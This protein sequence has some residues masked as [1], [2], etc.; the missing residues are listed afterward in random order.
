MRIS[1][2]MIF[3]S[4]VAR[5]SDLQASTLKTQQQISTG[6]RVLTPADDPIAAARALEVTQS[7]SINT[8]LTTNRKNANDSLSLEESVL[9]NVTGLYQDVKTLVVNAGNGT[10]SDSER[11]AMASALSGRL[12]ELTGLAN[13]RDGGG[14]YIFSGYQV[15]NPAF[16]TGVAGVTYNG[17]QGQRMLQVSPSQQMAISDT[18]DQ[19]FQSIKNG[20]GTFIAAGQ[21][22]VNAAGITLPLN[23]GSGVISAGNVT[24]PGALTGHNYEVDFAVTAGVTTYSVVDTTSS[25]TLS[26][27]NPYTPGQTIAFDG[28]QFDISGAPADTDK[29]TVQPS[30]NQSVFT[31]MNN[32]INTLKTPS[33]GAVGQANLTNGLNAANTGIDRALDNVLTIRASIGSRMNELDALDTL[34]ASR[35]FQYTSTL[36]D[37]QDVDY[38]AAISSLNAQQTTLDAAQKSFVKVTGLSLFSLL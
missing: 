19:V 2:N 4:G 17:D 5:I 18:G 15:T 3:D 37:L 28:M 25:T 31:I 33:G 13:S 23:T 30:A 7:Q 24:N 10:V 35:D 1:T 21:S 29:F 20:N 6:H 36:G 11:T 12:D 8:Q 16:A 34:G 26:A 14:N 22:T 27:A 9:Q 38:A 32:L